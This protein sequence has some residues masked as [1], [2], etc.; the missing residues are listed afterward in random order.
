MRTWSWSPAEKKAA[1]KAF[2]LALHCELE[3]VVRKAKAKAERVT[4]ASELWE[5]EEWLGKQRRRIDS[6]YDFR[7]SVLPFTF[8]TLIHEGR[9]REDDLAGLADEKLVAIR[10]VL[11]S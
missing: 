2:D 7:Y 4:H 5:L 9:L 1:R 8:A 11:R 6:T 10:A 3:D